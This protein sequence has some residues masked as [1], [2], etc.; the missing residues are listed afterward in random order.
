MKNKKIITLICSIILVAI[1]TVGI[2]VRKFYNEGFKLYTYTTENYIGTHLEGIIGIDDGKNYDGKIKEIGIKEINGDYLGLFHI[3][4]DIQNQCVITKYKKSF[5]LGD[6]NVLNLD[7][8]IKSSSPI[9]MIKLNNNNTNNFVI[10]IL[11]SSGNYESF[12][13][14]SSDSNEVI[15]NIELTDEKIE[16]FGG[17]VLKENAYLVQY[18]TSEYDELKIELVKKSEE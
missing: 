7:K 3:N 17:E 10:L 1:L 11:K 2:I 13:I 14:V 18:E 8:V 12:N 4:D 9:S 15:E 5:D 16:E 6:Y